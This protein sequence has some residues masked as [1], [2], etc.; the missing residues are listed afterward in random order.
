MTILL[1]AFALSVALLQTPVDTPLVITNV[2]VLPMNTDRVL[3]AQ[4]VV[5]EHG[6]IR[7]MGPDDPTARPAVR[8][9]GR[10]IDGTGKYLM[11]GLVDVHVHFHGNPP[12]EHP[13]LLKLFLA[14]GV[15]TIVALRGYPQLLELRSAV[16]AG[17][18]LGPRT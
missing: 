16:N 7:Y 3:P 11:P 4:T 14:N 15:T 10:L 12:E 17:R 9:S 2:N 13:H 8:P 1:A 6:R 18:I 5:I